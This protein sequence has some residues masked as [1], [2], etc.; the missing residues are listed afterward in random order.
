MSWNGR[1]PTGEGS[2]LRGGTGPRSDED[3]G[4]IPIVARPRPG[5]LTP[6]AAASRLR[7]RVDGWLVA[8][9][10][11]AVPIALYSAKECRRQI[12]AQRPILRSDA[13]FYFAFLPSLLF[14]HDLDFG[15]D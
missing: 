3:T 14:D 12:L 15:N 8:L 13:A 5:R 6:F 4:A 1:D 11:L 7:R 10:L 9:A 2:P